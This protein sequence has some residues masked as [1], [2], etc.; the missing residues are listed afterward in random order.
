[1][2][3]RGKNTDNPPLHGGVLLRYMLL[4]QG[5]T[6]DTISRRIQSFATYV[7][8]AS[9]FATVSTSARN[10]RRSCIAPSINPAGLQ[11]AVQGEDLLLGEHQISSGARRHRD[12][13]IPYSG[14]ASEYLDFEISR[15]AISSDFVSRDF[16]SRGS[17]IVGSRIS[18]FGLSG[19]DRSV[20]EDS[21]PEGARQAA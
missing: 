20:T 4:R 14:Y 17:L 6:R 12:C 13:G 8:L 18:S 1:M 7:N 3:P 21:A 19:G 9:M 11:R 10:R 15:V 2:S 5:G 16:V